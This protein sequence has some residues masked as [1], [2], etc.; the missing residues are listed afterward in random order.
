MEYNND[1]LTIIDDDFCDEPYLEYDEEDIFHEWYLIEGEERISELSR[2]L[3]TFF[4]YKQ[5]I[6]HLKF[7]RPKNFTKNSHSEL[8]SR[9][10]NDLITHTSRFIVLLKNL[11]V[12]DGDIAEKL[13]NHMKKLSLNPKRAD[14]EKLQEINKYCKKIWEILHILSELGLYNNQSLLKNAIKI[15]CISC[16]VKTTLFPRF[17]NFYSELNKNYLQL[18]KELI[19]AH[20][21]N[22]I[23][24]LPA[25]EKRTRVCISK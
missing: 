9:Y 6:I 21:V 13:K 14:I 24:Q 3:R 12:E 7:S 25:K 2:Q 8:I 20:Q 15:S 23:D 19:R 10:E 1:K 5:S 4:N 11:E 17:S 16:E 22:K 18:E